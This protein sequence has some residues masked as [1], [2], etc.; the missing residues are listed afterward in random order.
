MFLESFQ[1][2]LGSNLGCRVAIHS[3]V[4]RPFEVNLTSHLPFED[5]H[6]KSEEVLGRFK[7]IVYE[8]Q[9]F[10]NCKSGKDPWYPF[11]CYP[12]PISKD[13]RIQLH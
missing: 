8:K 3:S 12:C 2:A 13:F 1:E 4:V 5:Q 6:S 10:R 11:M 7:E 9:H